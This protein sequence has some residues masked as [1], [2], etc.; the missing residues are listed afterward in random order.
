[1]WLI[2]LTICEQENWE[3]LTK[4]FAQFIYTIYVCTCAIT[5]GVSIELCRFYKPIR[6]KYYF[7]KHAQIFLTYFW[8]HFQTSHNFKSSSD[9]HVQQRIELYC[10]HLWLSTHSYSSYSMYG[11]QQ[12]LM[13]IIGCNKAMWTYFIWTRLYLLLPESERD[14]YIIII[15]KKKQK[16][17]WCAKDASSDC[18]LRI[19]NWKVDFTDLHVHEY[20]LITITL[21]LKCYIIMCYTVVNCALQWTGRERV[22]LS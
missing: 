14:R 17:V 3:I 2:K 9:K 6:C 7:V 18:I 1:M 10:V 12:L 16:L 13:I 20:G 19:W 5:N 11:L 15:K 4:L 8:E 22:R 21:Y